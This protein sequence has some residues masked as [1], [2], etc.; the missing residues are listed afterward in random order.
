MDLESPSLLTSGQVAQMF[1]VDPAT[2]RR[3][4]NSGV[5]RTVRVGNG[6]RRYLPDEV[7]ALYRV[8]W[9]SRKAKAAV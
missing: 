7:E 8:S 3:W 6:H 9:Y 5:L 1:D 4:A 2:V